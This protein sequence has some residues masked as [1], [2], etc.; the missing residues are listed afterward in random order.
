MSH[1]STNLRGYFD[2][3]GL[4]EDDL[5]TLTHT[6]I[7]DVLLENRFMKLFAEPI[8][9][10]AAFMKDPDVTEISRGNKT[11]GVHAASGA[12]YERFELVL[13]KGGRVRR[14]AP[15]A[16]EVATRRFSLLL[17]TDVPGYNIG[18][19]RYYEEFYLGVGPEFGEEGVRIAAY[20]VLI[21][22]R[23]VPKR[24]RLLSPLG[25]GYYR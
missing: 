11:F 15:D 8:H 2:H 16:I 18:L 24:L 5:E 22:V 25:W 17:T 1:L 21:H 19:P 14:I 10:R 23:I 9:E 6:D 13:P 3:A 20:S 4:D 7:P 12:R